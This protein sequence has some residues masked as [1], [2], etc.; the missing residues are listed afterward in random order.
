MSEDDIPASSKTDL[1]GLEKRLE[2][3]IE[4]RV[5]PAE[6]EG[7]APVLFS[8]VLPAA[9]DSQTHQQSEFDPRQNRI[10]SIIETGKIDFTNKNKVLIK[11]YDGMNDVIM[12]KYVNIAPAENINYVWQERVEWRPGSYTVDFYE[13]DNNVRLLATGSYTVTD[14]AEYIGSLGVY[15]VPQA[16]YTVEL[17]KPGDDIWIRFN[18]SAYVDM[19]VR[20]FVYE[21]VLKTVLLDEV[22]LLPTAYHWQKELLLG[23]YV[24]EIKPGTYYVEVIDTSGNLR[25]RTLFHLSSR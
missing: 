10:Y 14:E 16:P 12:F 13:L 23:D 24:A 7:V 8:T 18:Y 2:D 20:L 25:G 21:V 1:A 15:D 4:N 17:F 6:R 5:A 11:W 9:G 22:F 19:S 3:I